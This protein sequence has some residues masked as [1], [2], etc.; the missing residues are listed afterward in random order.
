MHRSELFT[1]KKSKHEALLQA[2]VFGKKNV[3]RTKAAMKIASFSQLRRQAIHIRKNAQQIFMEIWTGWSE[4][5]TSEWLWTLACY[6][7]DAKVQSNVL[8]AV[9]W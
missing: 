6:M 8:H 2:L 7:D 5:Q 1:K 9:R 4:G 3:W